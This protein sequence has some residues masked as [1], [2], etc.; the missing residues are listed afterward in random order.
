MVTNKKSTKMESD[1]E[2]FARINKMKEDAIKKIKADTSYSKETEEF[3]AKGRQIGKDLEE[4]EEC[5]K[6]ADEFKVNPPIVFSK[7]INGISVEYKY[8]D[9]F[10]TKIELLKKHNF[11][12]LTVAK[13]T[14]ISSPTFKAMGKAYVR[15]GGQ[16]IVLPESSIPPCES[17][18]MGSRL[19]NPNDSVFVLENGDIIETGND[20]Y[21]TI[22]DFI[23]ND[24]YNREIFIFPN[25]EV[26]L[27]LTKKEEHPEPA[28][29][30][31]SQVP[32]VIKRNSSSTVI[33]YNFVAVSLIKGI[34]QIKVLDRN[35]NVNNL[36]KFPAGYPNFEFLP[37]SKMMENIQDN[38]I[39]KMPAAIAAKYIAKVGQRSSKACDEISAYLELCRDNS[40]A[41]FGTPNPIKN[42]NSGKIGYPNMPGHAPTDFIITSKITIKGDSIYSD[43]ANSIDPRARAIIKNQQAA[44][45]Y[46]SILNSKKEYEQKLKELVE[47]KS[48]QKVVE[49]EA[50]KKDKESRK[51]ELLEQQKYY[52]QVGDADMAAATQMQLDEIE[53]PKETDAMKKNKELM[54]KELLESL[55]QAKKA[56]NT[57][58]VDTIQLQLEILTNPQN[59]DTS[60]EGYYK[61][62]L[63]WCDNEIA[64][65]KSSLNTNF[66]PYNPLI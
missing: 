36:L 52:K 57:V 47:K 49:S 16:R 12:F 2:F 60:T 55:E 33:K 18:G 27:I 21:V 38:L 26:S 1:A 30:D 45:Q 37:S 32:D 56:N 50:S 51:T 44:N 7:S 41:I 28:F 10:K 43:P 42:N 19:M 24:D 46:Q 31:P 15:R 59:T 20:S 64:K 58:L 4:I 48:K 63:V 5:Q 13:N 9:K 22:N 54:K 23:S 29:M 17:M 8:D 25:S 61:K 14:H 11:S 40:V 66:P 6:I 3:K 35:K 39:A 34:F 65:L 62:M 53:P